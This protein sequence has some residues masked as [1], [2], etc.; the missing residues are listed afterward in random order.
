MISWF[1]WFNKACGAKAARRASRTCIYN[2]QPVLQRATLSID[3]PAV[4][5][6]ACLSK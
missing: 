3:K 1:S 2:M 6:G 4:L 5:A